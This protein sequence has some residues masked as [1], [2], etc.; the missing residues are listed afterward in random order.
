MRKIF[1]A[2]AAA[3]LLAGCTPGDLMD[4]RASLKDMASA[5]K[6]YVND[7]VQIRKEYRSGIHATVRSEYAALMFAADSANRQGDMEAAIEHW[8]AA[9]AL[10][11]EHMPKLKDMKKRF[12]EF[13]DN[14]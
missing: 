6:S 4:A 11:A 5:A 13:F 8:A 12:A 1:L 2:A 3:L 14:D 9:R 10:Y 7:Q